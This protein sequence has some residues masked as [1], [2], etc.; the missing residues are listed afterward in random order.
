MRVRGRTAMSAVA[1]GAIS[2]GL[3]PLAVGSLSAGA[4]PAGL[5]GRQALGSAPVPVGGRP[6]FTVDSW[7]NPPSPGQ[8]RAT[9]SIPT[10]A[11]S[12]S[13]SGTTYDYTMVGTNPASGSATTT[14]PT[15][16]VPLKVVM[17]NGITTAGKASNLEAS[18]I[19]TKAAFTSGTTQLADAM[20]RASLWTTVS[21]VAPHYH[22][23]LGPPTVLPTATISVPAADGTGDTYNGISYAY[24]DYNWWVSALQGIMNADAFS[25]ATLPILVSGNTFLYLNGNQ[26]DCC[27]YGYHGSYNSSSGSNTYVFSN[28]IKAGLVANGSR[29]VYTM[30]HEISEWAADPYADNI[31]PTWNQPD[32]STCYSD[33]L[34]V[35][36]PVD[37]LPTPWYTINVGTRA[38]HPSDIAGVSWFSQASPSTG[39]GGL[40]SY[41]SYLTGPASLC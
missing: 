29:D 1:V 11:G 35:G 12:F 16:I 39:K 38:Y 31:V 4:A 25:A 15:E 22:V 7:R 33:L 5:P 36:D 21:T 41:K 28:W 24:I 18:P 34:E 19:F 9:G 14:I 30:S 2:I 26:S 20:Q 10:W 23:L 3:G 6:I 27:V 17:A 40:Y 32:G 13:Y 8:G 37:A